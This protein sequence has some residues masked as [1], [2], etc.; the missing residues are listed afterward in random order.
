MVGASTP[1]PSKQQLPQQQQPPR[2]DG[3]RMV[4]E[5]DISEDEDG[6]PSQA[7]HRSMPLM[8]CDHTLTAPSPAVALAAAAPTVRAS[9]AEPAKG[10]QG[11]RSSF[12]AGLSLHTSQLGTASGARAGHKSNA[13]H[14]GVHARLAQRA[15]TELISARQLL[16]VHHHILGRLPPHPDALANTLAD[17]DVR[18]RVL[19]LGCVIATAPLVIIECEEDREEDRGEGCAGG[20]EDAVGPATAHAAATADDDPQ[21]VPSLGSASA[22]PQQSLRVVL[23]R[24]AYERVRVGGGRIV[25]FWPWIEQ[26]LGA[27]ELLYA[28][29]AEAWPEATD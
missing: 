27:V 11:V 1:A 5:E 19:H 9:A 17:A 15:A 29:L 13:K 22:L 3:V 20:H 10:G 16:H 7:P 14:S 2:A 18:R 6:P 24:S 12:V 8:T 4:E 28:P 25:V 23:Q 26:H 21:S